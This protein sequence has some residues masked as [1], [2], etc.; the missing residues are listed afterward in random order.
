VDYH[1]RKQSRQLIK[2]LKKKQNN[3]YKDVLGYINKYVGH[4]TPIPTNSK[5]NNLK[6]KKFS[7]SIYTRIYNNLVK[8]RSDLKEE[9]ENRSNVLQRHRVLPGH[10]GGK[11]VEDNCTYL[12]LREHIIAHYLLWKIH[13]NP[14]DYKAYK[15]MSGIDTPFS[16]HSE[17]TKKRLSKSHK[18]VLL[19]EEHR[20]KISEGQRGRIPGFGDK[21][22]SD[23]T[24]RKMSESQKGREITKKHRENLSN[25]RKKL[26]GSWVTEEY[27]KNMANIVRG[28]KHSEETK[29]K[30]KDAWAKRKAA[31]AAL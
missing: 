15:M 25:S 29:R 22:H 6:R 5:L 28:R 17:Y 26:N 24:K 8:T 2:K 27:R 13:R 18:G 1:Q 11:Y 4:G 31:K 16:K 14:G 12:T 9:W 19:S 20:R 21:K 3:S 30:M 7:M 23:E 10:Q